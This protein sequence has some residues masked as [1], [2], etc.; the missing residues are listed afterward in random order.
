MNAETET[1]GLHEGPPEVAA[2]PTIELRGVARRY[3]TGAGIVTALE[4]IDLEI[5]AGEFVVVLGPSGSGSHP[6]S[7]S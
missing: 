4:R 3:M 7:S 5:V 1:V 2:P 6:T